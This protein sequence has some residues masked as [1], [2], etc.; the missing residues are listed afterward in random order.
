MITIE[1]T[2]GP[3]FQVPYKAKMNAQ[4][5]MEEV[6]DDPANKNQFTFLLQYYGSS[7]GYLVDMING[8][9][10]TTVIGQN[11]GQPYFFWDIL[12]NGT[13]ATKGI[14]NLILNDNDKIGFNFQIY[15]PTAHA[16]T[17]M[18]AKRKKQG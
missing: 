6:I 16:G 10:D 9:Y 3:T 8:T 12:Y 15:D 17:T 7:L 5:A 14:D 2:G 18:E 1:I 4:Q 13:S 11:I